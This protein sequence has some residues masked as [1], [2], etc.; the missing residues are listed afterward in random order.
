MKTTQS[1][2][3]LI[4]IQTGVVKN[5]Y[6]RITPARKGKSEDEQAVDLETIIEVLG[7]APIDLQN[8]LVLSEVSKDDMLDCIRHLSEILNSAADE[9]PDEW[10][11]ILDS[12][13]KKTKA[14]E[15]LNFKTVIELLSDW[16]RVLPPR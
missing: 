9:P 14:G 11:P 3:F 2:K 12:L 8:L 15:V 6:W 4:N 1:S 16:L 13:I 10:K 5:D 7:D